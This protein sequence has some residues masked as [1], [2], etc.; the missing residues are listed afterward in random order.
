M[1]ILTTLL[2]QLQPPLEILTPP[3]S[4]GARGFHPFSNLALIVG[5]LEYTP[6]CG[7]RNRH[8]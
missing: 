6:I 8:G 5:L 3:A 1:G 4:S 7:G 2:K